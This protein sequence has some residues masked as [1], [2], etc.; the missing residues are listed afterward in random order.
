MS[1]RDQEMY[2]A[3]INF[4]HCLRVPQQASVTALQSD[5]V[6][7]QD[8]SVTIRQAHALGGE[9]GWKPPAMEGS[10][11]NMGART[12]FDATDYGIPAEW[13]FP[14]QEES[15]HDYNA[16][17]ERNGGNAAAGPI[18]KSTC[19]T[20]NGHSCVVTDTGCNRRGGCSRASLFSHV[21]LIR[22]TQHTPTGCV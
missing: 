20:P 22:L 7:S 12:P 1:R 18:L 4:R 16:Q 6:N 19:L 3:R 2:T 13:K 14:D 21:L 17:C 10:D 15:A 9:T 11:L 8:I 5:G